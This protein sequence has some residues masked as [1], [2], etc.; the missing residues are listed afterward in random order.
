MT[1]GRAYFPLFQGSF[2]DAFVD[3]ANTIRN[4][5]SLAYH[6]TNPAQDGTYRK[7]KVELVAP[8]TEVPLKMKDEKGRDVKYQIVSREGYNAKREV[9]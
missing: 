5:Y 9:E 4:Q 8:G 1:G 6:P 7:I 2:K 3:V